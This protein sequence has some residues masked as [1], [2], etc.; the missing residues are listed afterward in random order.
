MPVPG[1]NQSSATLQPIAIPSLPDFDCA[2]FVQAFGESAGKDFRH[3]LHDY[4]RR[5]VGGQSPKKK[6]QRLRP[7]G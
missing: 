5:T 3:M 7:S 2:F 1:S 4:D 6:T